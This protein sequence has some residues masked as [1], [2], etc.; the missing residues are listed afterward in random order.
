MIEW[1]GLILMEYSFVEQE[2]D[3]EYVFLFV[4]LLL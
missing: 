1:F 4:S 3:D 2:G